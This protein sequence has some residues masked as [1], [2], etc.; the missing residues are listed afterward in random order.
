M[1]A[2]SFLWGQSSCG[3]GFSSQ[4]IQ[5]GT[6]NCGGLEVFVG[7]EGVLRNFSLSPISYPLDTFLAQTQLRITASPREKQEGENLRVRNSR[8]HGV[9]FLPSLL[10]LCPVA[11]VQEGS[12]GTLSASQV[13]SGG[14]G[15]SSSRVSSS[16]SA[17][18]FC[19]PVVICCAHV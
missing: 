5:R 13:C 18:G 6:G 3:A 15:S 1:A 9:F 8:L 12:T 7:R 17:G 2:L 4:L 10:S 19:K 16:L 11:A 14:E